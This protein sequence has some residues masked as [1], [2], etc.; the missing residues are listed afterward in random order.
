LE[1]THCIAISIVR[2]KIY[3]P[4]RT[5]DL[6]M[7]IPKSVIE[8]WLK[9]Y[10][11]DSTLAAQYPEINLDKIVALMSRDC[12]I[13]RDLCFAGT[14]PSTRK[15]YLATAG[16]PCAG[17]STILEQVMLSNNRYGNLVKVDPDRWGMAYMVHS[18]T[19]Y[20]MGAAMTANAVDFKAA[21]V[22]AY[23]V[24]R[25]ASNVISLEI[26]NEAVE[27]GY[28]IDLL[29][30]MASDETR[31]A[32]ATHR[33]TNQ[34][35]YQSTPEDVRDKGIL[36]TQRM[37]T[38]FNHADNLSFFWRDGAISNAVLAGTIKED[39]LDIIDEAAWNALSAKHDA[40]A[41]SQ[42]GI[43]TFSELLALR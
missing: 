25:P 18:Y 31:A 36:L 30:C 26:M 1:V 12:P 42:A 9:Q 5:G 10:A 16:A 14:L 19:A 8:G 4:K 39:S 13:V 35:Y 37:E 43:K 11:A 33:S 21:Q 3:R 27:K 23:N 40:D 29:V 24:C 7:V 28:A 17:K 20:M 2:A 15:V 22:R 6:I 34:G 38:L 32:S 41:A